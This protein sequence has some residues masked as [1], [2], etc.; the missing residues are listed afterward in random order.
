MLVNLSENFKANIVVVIA[1][2]LLAIMLCL[3]ALHDREHTVIYDCRI[4]EI[5]PDIPPK[6]RDECRKR[7]S[8]VGKEQKL[9]SKS[10]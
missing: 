6:V 8:D 1:T 5:S 4:A 7:S 3:S 2:L 10:I 9:E